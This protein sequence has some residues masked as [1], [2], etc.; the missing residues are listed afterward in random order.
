MTDESTMSVNGDTADWD[1]PGL[2]D[3]AGAGDALIV[4]LDGFEGPLDLLL[5]LART[6][7]VDLTKIAILPLVEQYLAFISKA[8]LVKLE[9]A[10][11]YLVMAAWLAYLKSKL[12]IPREKQ[13]PSTQ[14]AEEMAQRLAFRLMRL[15]AMRTAAA[16]LM[17]RKR[18]WARR[19]ARG[20]PER[21]KTVK[22]TTYTAQVYDLL[23]A[24]AEQRR[25]T[26]KVVHVVKARRVWSIKDASATAGTSHWRQ[27]GRLDPA[28]SLSGTIHAPRARKSARRW[29]VRSARRWKWRATGW[30]KFARTSR[31]RPFTC[32]GASLARS[33]KKSVKR[34]RGFGWCTA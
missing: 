21:V 1:A 29:Q 13:D 24:Y 18:L 19:F 16:R 8:Q 3:V 14:S 4:A 27:R 5:A 28:R 10:A 22:E 23:K 26:I 2:E 32:A 30:L 34:Q 20:L 12:L 33:G 11:D 31:L 7:K 9:L 6:Q 25:K 17:T 15:E